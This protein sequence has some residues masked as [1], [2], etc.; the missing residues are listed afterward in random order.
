[1]LAVTR[2]SAARRRYAAYRFGAYRGK[3]SNTGALR[4]LAGIGTRER[5]QQGRVFWD[6][7]VGTSSEES[8]LSYS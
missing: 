1:M 6:K 4:G 7:R 2:S 3:A 8:K 5:P